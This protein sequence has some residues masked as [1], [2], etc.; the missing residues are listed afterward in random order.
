MKFY[1]SVLELVGETPLVRLNNIVEPGMATIFA[2]METLNPTGSVKDRMAINMVKRAEELG[3]LKPGG[4]IVESTS[5]NTG[6][7]L[8]M[9]AAVK[10]YR[11]VFTIPDKMSQEKIDMLK[12]YGAEVIVTPTDLDHH[13]PD[14]Y[15]QVAKKVASATNG[16]FYTDQYY[17]MHNPEAH[18][19]TTGPEIWD[20]TDGKIDAFVAGL[21]T[22]GTISGAGKYLKEKAGDV[23][24]ELRVIG[25]DPY[26]SIYKEAFEVGQWSEPSLYR[27][28]GIGHDF[29]VGTLD[30]SVVDE[31]VNVS[32]RDSFLMA[33]RLAR[34]EGI[35]A[36]GSTGT[37]FVGALEEARKLGPGK[38]VV[39][40][41]CDSGDRYISKVFDDEWMRDMGYFSP[42]SRLG[43]VR[44]LL[45]FHTRPVLLASPDE[46]LEDVIAR[47][48]SLGISQMPVINGQK[49]LRMI[50]ELDILRAVA[51][52]EY[53]LKHSAID[54][55]RPLD[56]QIHPDQTLDQ[57]Q[58]IFEQNN[59]AVVVDGGVILGI[60]NKID[61]LEFITERNTRTMG[62]TNS[63][64]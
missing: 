38:I 52:G 46:T 53:T 54:I 23:G 51:G 30:F 63:P 55:A 9:A 13:H 26:G 45:N 16:A 11:C 22:G 29:M 62:T 27:V 3:L 43:T 36:G 39:A 4:T 28:E 15:V 59:V 50:E 14:N 32:D 10:G 41:V 56:G 44:D 24:R 20:A 1:S 33:R 31:V 47:M 42:D 8:A 17:N 2:K 25:P 12:A 5:G 40:I 19:L 57:V 34:K 61:V 60:I 48:A 64:N 49:D 58:R 37:V 18:Y 35:F 7:G 21:G 6:L